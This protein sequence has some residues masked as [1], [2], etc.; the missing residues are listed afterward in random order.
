MNKS[1]S[2]WASQNIFLA[3]I[4]LIINHLILGFLAYFVGLLLSDYLFCAWWQVLLGYVTFLF[5]YK[6]Y[7]PRKERGSVRQHLI[8]MLLT[9][10]FWTSY[11]V[12]IGNWAKKTNITASIPTTYTHFIAYKKNV[13]P[14]APTDNIYPSKDNFIVK[15]WRKNTLRD[16]KFI[17][18]FLLP[19]PE[20]E[21]SLSTKIIVRILLLLLVTGILAY[22]ALGFACQLSC[23]GYLTES[24]LVLGFGS[25]LLIGLWIW[26]VNKI[27]K[28]FEK[29]KKLQEK[30]KKSTPKTPAPVPV[31]KVQ[32]PPS[33]PL[34][35]PTKPKKLSRK[36]RKKLKQLDNGI[37]VLKIVTITVLTIVILAMIASSI[38]I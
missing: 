32:T 20:T 5:L 31:P 10:F 23:S 21:E 37:L 27:M 28:L 18:Q 8:L 12:S 7:F 30:S 25:A 36:E 22:L 14:I 4:L 2:L 15:L 34:P 33:A 19:D 24:Y 26:A 11:G 16:K 17:Q 1:L 9:F 29:I 6:T 3:R 35:P 13:E 38:F